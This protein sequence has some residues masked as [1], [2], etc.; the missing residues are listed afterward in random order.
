[1]EMDIRNGSVEKSYP[2][3]GQFRITEAGYHVAVPQR[4]HHHTKILQERGQ[5]TL[6]DFKS[7]LSKKMDSI[8]F[9]RLEIFRASQ[10]I[11]D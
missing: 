9:L 2:V 4:F 5:T 1:M 10:N 6:F 3:S 11:S 8:N 7:W